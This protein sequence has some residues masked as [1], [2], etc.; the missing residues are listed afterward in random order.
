MKVKRD[1]NVTEE[2]LASI[3]SNM[4]VLDKKLLNETMIYMNI[5]TPGAEHGNVHPMDLFT[6]AVV[7]RALSLSKGFRTLSDTNNYIA[8]VPLIRLQLDNSLRYFASMIVDDYN[9]FFMK[10]LGGEHIRNLRDSKGKLMT[11]NYLAKRL[12]KEL[13]KG[14]YNLYKNTS[15]YIHLSNRHSFIHNRIVDGDDTEMKMQ[16]TI[17]KDADFF[18]I[19]EKVDFAYNM[20]KAT[21]FLYKLVRSWKF[22]KARVELELN[23]TTDD[24]E[25]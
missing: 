24:S 11:D 4:D 7:N 6:N 17:G 22:Q 16:F 19:D 12:D 23:K 14:A 15:D 1:L 2:D 21:E 18:K 8:A 10:Y 20:F 9:D 5:G 13:F 25:E 3:Y